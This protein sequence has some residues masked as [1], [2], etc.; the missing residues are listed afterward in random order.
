MVIIL[1][2]ATVV[3][4]LLGGL[5]ALR[6]KDQLHLILGFSAGAVIGVAFF[7]LLPEA[8]SLAHTRY[9][10]ATLTSVVALGFMV[11]MLLD[12]WITLRSRDEEGRNEMMSY[13]RRGTLG[14]GSLSAHSFLDG[15]ALGLAFK[16]SNA[17][18]L[19]VATAVLVHDFSDGINTVNLVLKNQGTPRQALRWL[20]LDPIAPALGALAT[21]FFTLPETSLGLVLAMFCGFFL[22]LGASDLLPESYHA[23]STWWTTVATLLG[24]G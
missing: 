17:V 23:H 10:I 5:F 3:S 24:M 7:D 4:T 11:F 6:F 20:A 1:S 9:E 18:G 14:A 22:Y 8:I 15:L 2:L 13:S 16:V 21:L 19:I 12:R